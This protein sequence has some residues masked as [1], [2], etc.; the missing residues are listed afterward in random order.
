[1]KRTVTV[2]V[3]LTL[4]VSASGR[5]PLSDLTGVKPYTDEFRKV[6]PDGARVTLAAE[7]FK[8]TEGPVWYPPE[9]GWLFSDIPADTIHL[10]R[11]GDKPQVWR[12]PSR[13]A[14]GN[15]LGPDDALITCEHGT[16]QVTL[17]DLRGKV[18]MLAGEYEGKKFNSPNDAAVRSDGSVWFTDPTYG[19]EDR[20]QELDGCYVFRL[21]KIGADPELAAKGFSMPNGLCFSPDE[22]KLYIAD[23]DPKVHLVRVFPVGKDGKLGKPEQFA[24]IRPGVPDGIRCDSA[25]RLYVSAGDGVQVFRPDGKKIGL[26]KT[27]K[28]AANCA[29]GGP[30]G[31]VL[32]VTAR[33]KVWEVKLSAVGAVFSRARGESS[34]GGE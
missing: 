12:R 9:K 6:A 4:A 27:P 28:P 21:P 19:L 10:L 34:G 17:T 15:I 3:L 29:F 22:T 18:R 1:M 25:G 20:K 33:D 23:S 7:G 24:D 14:N 30:D 13:H 5:I 31:N 8:F 11:P 2:A 16:R 32:L 26:I